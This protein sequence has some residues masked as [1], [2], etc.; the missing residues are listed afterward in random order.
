MLSVGSGRQAVALE[1]PFEP[2]GPLFV[3]AL[4]AD[5]GEIGI[6]VFRAGIGRDGFRLI[7]GNT[8]LRFKPR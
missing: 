5:K 2:A 7:H 1:I 6:G 4:I 3:R 8:P